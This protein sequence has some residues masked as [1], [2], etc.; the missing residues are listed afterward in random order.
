MEKTYNTKNKIRDNFVKLGKL[1]GTNH[2]TIK[3]IFGRLDNLNAVLEIADNGVRVIDLDFNVIKVNKRFC[4]ISGVSKKEN[5]ARK[6]YEVFRGSDCQGSTCA[7]KQILSGKSRIEKEVKGI[8]SDN[9]AVP[10]ILKALPLKGIDEEII[11]IV[12]NFK[13]MSGIKKA[14]ESMLE[15]EKKYRELA[16]MLNEIVV[17]LDLKGR[18]VY[19]NKKAFE[20]TGYTKDRFDRGLNVMQIV[21]PKDRM[22][23]AANFRKLIKGKELERFIY[24][25][26]RRD[27]STFPAITHPSHILNS[28][29]KVTGIRV[30]VIDISD[31]KEAEEKIKESEEHYRLLFENSL[32][33]IYRTTLEGRY[34]DAN[35]SLVKMLG[36]DSKEELLA[37]DIPTQL[38]VRREDRPGPNKR[39]RIFETQLK[40]K[41]GSI[42]TVEINSRVIYKNG[43]SIHYE[44]IVRDITQRKITEGKLKESYQKLQKILNDIINMLAS[45]VETRDP[46]TS[47]HQKRVASLATAISAEMGLDKEKIESIEIAALIHDI[48]KINLPTSILTRP[49]RLSEIE[50]DMVKTHAQLGHDMLSRV[51]FPWP[52][53]DIILQ[54]HERINGSGYPEGLKG[55]D[56]ILEARILAVADV[57][58]AMASHRPYRPALGMDK[59][60]EEINEGRGKLYDS[61]V[62]DACTRLIKNKKFSFVV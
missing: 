6:C 41:D 5:L 11:G 51:E 60:L 12:E 9:K 50:Y 45:I 25:V 39:N 18:I 38:Y 19:A 61:E 10:C 58:E 54:H 27:G 3:K 4:K 56:I 13:D 62:V 31:I 29:G 20:A 2:R 59:A 42:I 33:G 17:E 52:I 24:T 15:S 43:K 8:R 36:Y 28:E 48:G 30:E 55:K 46:Y 47:G 7:L 57:V 23:L 49:G 26:R 32:D 53:A 14:E 22:K 37:I 35:P 40:K 1:K 44:G 16:E 34:I 21:V